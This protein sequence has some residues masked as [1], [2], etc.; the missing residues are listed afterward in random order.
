MQY[1]VC[2]RIMEIQKIQTGSRVA[3]VHRMWEV[4]KKAV[5]NLGVGAFLKHVCKYGQ[6]LSIV[7]LC[8]LSPH[9]CEIK[10]DPQGLCL[11]L[12]T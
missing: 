8:F 9:L 12:Q 3:L 6:A 5:K 11:F 4:F 2:Y 10:G 7:P 1:F